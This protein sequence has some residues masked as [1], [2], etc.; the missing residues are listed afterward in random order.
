MHFTMGDTVSHFESGRCPTCPG[1]D[2]AR[3]AAYAIARQREQD[4]GAQGLF[5]NGGPALLTFNG[6]G[7]QDF[8]Q[9]YVEGG[10]NFHCPGCRKG[11]KALGDMLKHIEA[12]PQ[13]G[14]SAGRLALM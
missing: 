8:T 7:R 6:D 1:R 9:G 3:R 5:T 2:N 4:A 13:C 10:K 12:K 11:F 14:Q